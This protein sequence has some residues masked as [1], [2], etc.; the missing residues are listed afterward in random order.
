MWTP[1]GAFDEV[2]PRADY[3]A[4][5]DR[6]VALITAAHSGKG[7]EQQEAREERDQR[8]DKN[9]GEGDSN[10]HNGENKSNVRPC[11]RTGT[12]SNADEPYC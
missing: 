5:L 10:E 9:S 4:S 6:L 8:G 1:R 11:W 7:D 12:Y 3:I 2:G